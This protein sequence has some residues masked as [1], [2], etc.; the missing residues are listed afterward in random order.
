MK[1]ALLA[2]LAA[3]AATD[4]APPSPP[5]VTPF[6]AAVGGA[7]NE[8]RGDTPEVVRVEPGA[9]IATVDPG[10]QVWL[11]GAMHVHA[12][13]SGDSTEPIPNVIAW[14]EKRGYDFIFLTDHNKVSEIDAT[15]QTPGQIA[16]RPPDAGKLI[17]MSGIELT[18]NPTNC[19]P[20]GDDQ[21]R[22]RIHVNLLGP[23]ARP[24]G[25]VDWPDRK[26]HDRLAKY[27]SALAQQRLLGGLA[28]INHP[29]WLWGMTSSLLAELATSGFT[30]VEIHNAAFSAW[31]AGDATHPTTEAIWDGALAMGATLWGVASDDAH[32]YRGTG[33][34]PAGGAWVVVRA[35]RDP[36]A[37]L[38]AVAAGHF[39][40]STGVVLDRVSVTK[41]EYTIEAANQPGM[42]A[43]EWIENGK[44]VA[45]IRGPRATRAL[46]ARGYLRA[47]ITRTDGA[48]AWVQPARR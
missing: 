7:S 17:V 1:A 18:H 9:Q 25:K 11:K 32:A 27:A 20:R 21:G 6:D 23:T 39:Y 4:V 28:Q 42:I 15:T 10:R 8:P 47:R 19:I 31:D 45:T 36:E 41:D 5:W 26:R 34:Y 33:S 12:K 2:L 48:R 29:N 14:Y 43:I 46:P 40:A 37:I 22:C 16:L 44:P 35:T 24:I 13:P 38:A 30:L 3:C